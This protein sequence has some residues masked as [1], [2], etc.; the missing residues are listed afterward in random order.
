MG[1]TGF[2]TVAS[3]TLAALL[4]AGTLSVPKTTYAAKSSDNAFQALDDSFGFRPGEAYEDFKRAAQ[5]LP[6][7]YDL[8]HVPDGKGGEVSYVTPVRLQNPYGTCWGYAGIA[9]AESSLLSSGIAQKDGFDVNTLDLSEKHLAYFATSH[10][11]DENNSQYGEG[12]YFRNIS[13]K[14][15]STKAYRY[16]TGGMTYMVTSCF[17]AGMGPVTEV[18]K[19]GEKPGIEQLFT[20]KGKRGE[21]IFREAATEYDD[22]GNPVESSYKLVPSWYSD[23][24][25]WSIPDQYKFVQSYRLKDS[26]VLPD[27]A[28]F[29]NKGN[30]EYQED[31]VNAIKQQIAEYNRAVCILFC[32]ESYLPGQD[33][34]GKSYMSDKWAHFTNV[35][36]YSNHAVTI[37]GYDDNYPKENFSSSTDNGGPAMPEN[38]GA[39]LIK[40]SWGSELNEFPTNGFRHWGILDGQDNVP[41]DPTAKAKKGNKATGYFWISYYDRSLNDPEAFIF[42]D[43]PVD[44]SDGGSYYV[45]QMDLLN[46]MYCVDYGVPECRMANVFE[47]EATSRLTDISVM[48]CAPGTAVSYEV[49]LLGEQFDDPEDGVLIDEGEEYFDFGGFHKI[50]IN[51]R[52]V[53]SKGQ[54]YSVIFSL[55]YKA[56]DFDHDYV[57]CPVSVNRANN[58]MY[59]IAVVNEGESFL[60]D[61]EEWEDFSDESVRD[62]FDDAYGIDLEVDNFSIKSY[63]EPIT[64]KEDGETKEFEGYLTVNNWADNNPGTFNLKVGESKTLVAEFRGVSGDLPSSWNPKFSWVADDEDMLDLDIKKPGK[65]EINITALKAGTTKLIVYAGD[66]SSDSITPDDYGIRVLTINVNKPEITGFSLKDPKFAATY[67]GKEIK[68][69]L[70]KVSSEDGNDDLKEGKD[71]KVSYKDNVDAGK[72]TVTVTGIGDYSGSVSKTFTIRRADN[73][74]SAEGKTAS[75]AYSTAQQTVAI[76]KVITFVNQGQGEKTYTKV[77]G[78]KNITVDEKTGNIIIAKGLAVGAYDLE[79]NIKAEGDNNHNASSLKVALKVNVTKAVNTLSVTGKKA[80]VSYKKLS[81]KNGKLALSKVI[82]VTNK[83]QGKLTYTKVGGNK[84]IVISKKGKVTVKK[85]LKKG[86]YKVKVNVTAAGNSYTNSVTKTVTFKVIVK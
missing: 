28:E 57:C 84:K 10:I 72:A 77:S 22:D 31:A 51:S 60:Y 56:E 76:S 41:Y 73:T 67:T 75:V 7:H 83:G 25:D 9:A 20:Y 45:E 39:F 37:V 47:T 59:N 78:D 11:E 74:F 48:T 21:K 69:E 61:G 63:L 55:K 62:I 42:D 17:A 35:P 15:E 80:N 3:I 79:I 40:N 71:Y 43:T 36:E 49:Y 12:Q 65:S 66:K 26:I 23:H 33:T 86:T 19:P 24:D 30:Y 2:K 70:G 46:S 53:L 68:P 27:P 6:D 1:K 58:D 18:S 13:P 54:K 4:A 8:R 64:Y 44:L 5:S 81:K 34:S 29:D 85:G 38:D 32:A 14:D 82:K 16:N 52:K 50:S